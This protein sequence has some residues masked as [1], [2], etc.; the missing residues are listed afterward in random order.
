ML[1][2][3][4]LRYLE[5]ECKDDSSFEGSAKLETEINVIYKEITQ[6][7]KDAADQCIIRKPCNFYKYWWDQEGDELKKESIDTHRLWI[8][9]GRPRNGQIYELKA[10][11][12]ARYKSYLRSNA[13]IEQSNVSNTLPDALVYKD[14]HMF[15]QMWK[16]KFKYKKSGSNSMNNLLDDNKIAQCFADYFAKNSSNLLDQWSKDM[17]ST[18]ISRFNNY[19]DMTLNCLRTVWVRIVF[20]CLY[21][22]LFILLHFCVK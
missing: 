16:K 21:I 13:K 17:E 15:W 2:L 7:L 10:K 14:N 22:V 20:A 9:S 4:K 12:K 1:T 5:N 18:F 3:E 19:N 11:A 8:E 6:K